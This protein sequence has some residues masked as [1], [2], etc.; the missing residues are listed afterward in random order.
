MRAREKLSPENEARLQAQ[1]EQLVKEYGGDAMEALKAV[2][3]H[4][5][6]LETTIRAV[7]KAH[8]GIFEISEE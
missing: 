4:V 3:L 7:D 5:G 6:D 1:A 8:P 2:M